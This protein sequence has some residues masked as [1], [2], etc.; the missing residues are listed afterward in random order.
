MKKILKPSIKVREVFTTTIS[1]VE[2]VILKEELTKC[3]DVLELGESDFEDKFDKNE[4]H[5][6]PQQL[7]I[8]GN[9]GKNEMKKVYDYRMVRSIMPG[10]KYYSQIKLSAKYGKCPLCSVRIVDTLD[11]YLPKSKYPIY[12]V[13]PINLIPSCTPCNKGKQID[14]PK[15]SK[16]QTLHPYF[17]D[18]ENDSWIK[19]KVLKTNPI[20]FEYFLD[21]PS[22][23]SKILEDRV[24]NHFISYNI[25][26]LFSSHANEEFIGSKKQFIKLYNMSPELLKAQLSSS[27]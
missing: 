10:Y 13:T 27:N 19:A 24:H 6:I 20:S 23:W 7:S 1:T 5:K 12:A 4:I 16:E 3:I 25:N 15:N 18:V 9:I 2:N 21:C 8:F 11:H 22:N 17:D 14:Y 26:E